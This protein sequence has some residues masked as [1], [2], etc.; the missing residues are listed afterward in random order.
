MTIE[1]KY[2][3]AIG[4]VP[5]IADQAQTARAAVGEADDDEDADD[6]GPPED[7][8]DLHRS[9]PTARVRK[10]LQGLATDHSGVAQHRFS[11]HAILTSLKF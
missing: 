2:S 7:A 5:H 6:D 1:Q 9:R 10:T 8:F 11:A 4:V 3:R